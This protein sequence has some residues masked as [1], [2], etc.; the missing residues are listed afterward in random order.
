MKLLIL[1]KYTISKNKQL[2]NWA[3]NRLRHTYLIPV[4]MKLLN[5]TLDVTPYINAGIDTA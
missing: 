3:N 2:K 5:D 1:K 4:I